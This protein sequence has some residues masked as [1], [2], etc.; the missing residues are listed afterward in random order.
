MVNVQCSM[1]QPRLGA[2]GLSIEH[3]PQRPPVLY[4]SIPPT[5]KFRLEEL[6][7][8]AR[9]CAVLFDARSKRLQHKDFR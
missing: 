2:T 8:G 1:V 4:S 9:L 3:L 6:C 7:R 5:P